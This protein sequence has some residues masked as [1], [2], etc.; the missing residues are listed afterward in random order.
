[1]LRKEVYAS[2]YGGIEKTRKLI[3]L[4]TVYATIQPACNQVI[5]SYDASLYATWPFIV[6]RG[7]RTK[8]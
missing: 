2:L 6:R 4:K 7:D 3:Y 5:L 1:M 8:D